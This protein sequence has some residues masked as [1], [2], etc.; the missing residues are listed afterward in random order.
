[1]AG[2]PSHIRGD[3]FTVYGQVAG[4]YTGWTGSSQVRD[5]DKDDLLSE[6]VFSWVD[7][8]QG[9]FVVQ[10]L[11]TSNWPAN[12]FVLFDVQLTSPAGIIASTRAVRI[13]VDRDATQHT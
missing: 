8:A 11:D 9:M 2:D 5:D 13:R 10:V 7:A 6:L 1:M 12:K 4:D 3:T